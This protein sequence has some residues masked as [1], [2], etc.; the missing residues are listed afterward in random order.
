MPGDGAAK[1]IGGAGVAAAALVAAASVGAVAGAVA[2]GAVA[3]TCGC[4]ALVCA[5]AP[6][7]VSPVAARAIAHPISFI[8]TPIDSVARKGPP[9]CGRSR[10]WRPYRRDLRLPQA[11]VAG[12]A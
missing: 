11:A 9:T 3:V 4:A 10:I 8:F 5:A 1:S 6:A 2:A 12:S 7:G